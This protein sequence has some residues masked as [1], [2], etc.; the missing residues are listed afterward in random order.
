MNPKNSKT[1]ENFMNHGRHAAAIHAR[2]TPIMVY[3]QFTNRSQQNIM[4]TSETGVNTGAM[5]LSLS[6]HEI[7]VKF[8]SWFRR[9][10]PGVLIFAIPNGGHRNRVTAMKLKAEGVVSG[11]PDL[12][13]PD[14][15]L[16]IEMKK[17]KGGTVSA[18]Q[19]SM[20]KYLNDI[21]HNA[22]VCRG[23]DHAVAKTSE[24]AAQINL[25]ID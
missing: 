12:F 2:I 24:F 19:K 6:E 25:F 14:W 3:A 18:T 22:I 5:N 23:F 9:N 1:G 21:G 8:I 20:I 13:I 10:F 15:L 4:Q 7:Q 11:I 17:E 16:W